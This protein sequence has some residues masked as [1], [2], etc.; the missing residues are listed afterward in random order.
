MDEYIFIIIK[1]RHT[2]L[3]FKINYYRET[4]IT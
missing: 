3:V 1:N 2:G 4:S